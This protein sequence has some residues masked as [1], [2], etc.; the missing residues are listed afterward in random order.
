MSFPMNTIWTASVGLFVLLSCKSTQVR[1]VVITQEVAY[2]TDDPAIWVNQEDPERSLILGT[3]KHREGGLY[4]FDLNGKIIHKI[5]GIK[6]PNNID[7]E[8]GFEFNGKP[9]DIAVVTERE[10]HSLRVFSLPDMKAIDGGGIPVFEGEEERSPMGIA[11]YKH[12]ETQNV[13]AI[14]S[15]KSGPLEGY[16]GQYELIDQ[17][18]VVTGK[19]VRKFGKYSGRKEIESIAVDDAEGYVYYSDEKFGV[20]KYSADPEKGNGQL[21]AFGLQDFLSD[22]EGISIYPTG[23]RT[24]YIL[25]SNQQANT[26]NVYRREGEEGKPHQHVRIAE[27]PLSTIESDGS[28]VSAVNFGSRF[29]K[30]IFAAMSNGK[31]F[32]LYDWRDIERR[33]KK[34]ERK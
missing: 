34:Q 33:I 2:D 10:T 9:I 26:F 22:V 14:V 13:Y 20:R 25:V 21:G 30:G 18:G 12:P 6:R 32:H 27:I 7:I 17:S 15:R 19:Y 4:A 3:D 8:Y 31:V 24:G 29:P 1:P 11:L 23:A 16:L 5:S 28:E